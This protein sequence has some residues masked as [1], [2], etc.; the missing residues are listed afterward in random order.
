MVTRPAWMDEAQ[1]L[2]M[3]TEIFFPDVLDGM[4]W[5]QAKA[6]CESCPVQLA[7]LHWGITTGATDGI[8]GGMGPGQRRE[9]KRKHHLRMDTGS[10]G[11]IT[12]PYART[13]RNGIGSG[14]VNEPH[15]CAS[16]P[17]K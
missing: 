8:F 12:L 11:A 16:R 4:A 2:Y 13:A 3:D 10:T 14:T 9:Y 17:R 6:V 7:C 5:K 15:S 1:C